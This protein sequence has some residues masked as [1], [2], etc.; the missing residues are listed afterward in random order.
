LIKNFGVPVQE[1]AA[2]ARLD[3][4]ER[5]RLLRLVAKILKEDEDCVVLYPV[6]RQAGDQV[7]NIG[8]AR[9]EIPVQSYYFTVE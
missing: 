2:E 1:R 4:G 6:T 7:I 5:E 9:P 8:L 3:R